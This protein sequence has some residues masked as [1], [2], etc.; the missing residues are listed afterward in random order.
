[1]NTIKRN[2]KKKIKYAVGSAKERGICLKYQK[3]WWWL[4][5]N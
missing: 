4:K 5:K 1:L 3:K 2:K